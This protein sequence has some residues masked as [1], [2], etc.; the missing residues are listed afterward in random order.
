MPAHLPLG[1]CTYGFCTAWNTLPALLHPLVKFSW[2]ALPTLEW[3]EPPLCFPRL[4]HPGLCPVTLSSSLPPMGAWHSV[5]TSLLPSFSQ[6]CIYF[7]IKIQHANQT[8]QSNICKKNQIHSTMSRVQRVITD[9]VPAFKEFMPLSL[10]KINVGKMTNIL[11]S[12]SHVKST[13]NVI[14]LGKMGSEKDLWRLERPW[15]ASWKR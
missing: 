10:S 5:C 9:T 11:Q 8:N 1:L 6:P 3:G 12:M 2:P 14:H 13:V 7:S 15:E 4:Q